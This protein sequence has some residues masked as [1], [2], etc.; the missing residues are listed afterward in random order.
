MAAFTVIEADTLAS[1]ATSW[2]SGTI[3]TTYD[4]LYITMSAKGAGGLYSQGTMWQFNGDTGANYTH[5]DIQTTGSTPSTYD[6]SGF[7]IGYPPI[8]GAAGNTAMFGL[9]KIWIPNYANTANYKQALFESHAANYTGTSGHW[10]Y[11]VTSGQWLSTAAITS[12][13]VAINGGTDFLAASTYT[14]YGVN[15]A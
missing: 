7:Q 2:T 6:A 13:T 14:I 5:V 8:M 1:D 3:P 15:G 9:I 4:H 10:E 12:F 11:K